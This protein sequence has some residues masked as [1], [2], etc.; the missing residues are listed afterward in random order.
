MQPFVS[1]FRVLPPA[2]AGGL[3]D[4]VLD[5]FVVSGDLFVYLVQL[6][7]PWT[8]LLA[9]IA[10]WLFA[11]NWVKLR[12]VM[13]RGGFVGVV[14]I[15]LVWA[16]VWGTVSPVDQHEMLGLAVGNYVGKMMY[17]TVLLCI[18]FLCGSLQLAGF[19]PACCRFTEEETPAAEDHPHEG[20]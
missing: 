5:L 20:H 6:I 17:V 4:R 19:L 8:P 3:W 13:V 12:D 7:A 18:M 11:V 10:F 9:W 2:E 16:L 14:L 1:I 15:G